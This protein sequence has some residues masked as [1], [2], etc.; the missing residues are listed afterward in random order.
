MVTLHYCRRYIHWQTNSSVFPVL[1]QTL[2]DS[3]G[4]KGTVRD[5]LSSTL[6]I[7][8]IVTLLYKVIILA[9]FITIL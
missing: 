3:D 5:Y 2:I 7:R 1:V 4:F 9:C 8:P 6:T